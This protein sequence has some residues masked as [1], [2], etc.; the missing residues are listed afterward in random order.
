MSGL[1]VAVFTYEN[2]KLFYNGRCRDSFHFKS[3]LDGTVKKFYR[4]T[5][6]QKIIR[7]MKYFWED[8]EYLTIK[9][10]YKSIDVRTKHISSEDHYKVI[11]RSVKFFDGLRTSSSLLNFNLETHLDI[12]EIPDI[13]Y[14][15]YQNMTSG[16]WIRDH[17]S[18]RHC[19]ECGLTL[20]KI[21]YY[22]PSNICAFCMLKIAQDA[23]SQISKYLSKDQI[24]D[25]KRHNILRTVGGL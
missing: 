25:I 16:Q 5:Y 4:K 10:D 12:N 9:W 19:P 1:Y 21:P 14:L 24:L 13:M 22:Y 18:Q 15:D 7:L 23:S 11:S 3:V 17:I 2:K 6:A 20:A 8:G